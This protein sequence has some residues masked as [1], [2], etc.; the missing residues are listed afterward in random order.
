[1]PSVPQE[2]MKCGR[3]VDASCC[4][5]PQHSS[6]VDSFSFFFIFAI[7]Q[8]SRER[9][10]AREGGRGSGTAADQSTKLRSLPRRRPGERQKETEINLTGVSL[11]LHSSLCSLS[12]VNMTRLSHTT[13]CV[14]HIQREREFVNVQ[15]ICMHVCVCEALSGECVC[16]CV[17]SLWCNKDT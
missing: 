8:G 6:I 10:R 9:E 1:M 3:M 5:M 17:C 15:L 14:W 11:V 7:M 13:T 16:V 12:T 4:W 2:V